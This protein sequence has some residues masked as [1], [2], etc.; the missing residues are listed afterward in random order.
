MKDNL[1]RIERFVKA[2]KPFIVVQYFQW[3][4]TVKSEQYR[5]Y[6]IVFLDTN[7]CITSFKLTNKGLDWFRAN[8]ELFK[9]AKKDN[10][11][12]TIYEFNNFKQFVE[13][14]VPKDKRETD[15]ENLPTI[16]IEE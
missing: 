8:K 10:E 12:G 6:D 4:R 13:N 9:I 14:E 5:A 1:T 11:H 7:R 15:F 3:M 2:K 16:E